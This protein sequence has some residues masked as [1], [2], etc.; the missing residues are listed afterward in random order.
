MKPGFRIDTIWAFVAIGDDGEEGLVGMLTTNGW[1]PFVCADQ[2]RVDGLRP[3]AKQVAEETG[4][5]VT[6]V[7]F[8]GPRLEL[9]VYG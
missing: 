6:L 3:F 1:M 9:E 2:S 8:A 5:P 4:R 7:Q